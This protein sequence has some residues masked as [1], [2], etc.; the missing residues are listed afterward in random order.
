M[1]NLKILLLFPNTSSEGVLPLAVATLS[2][3]AKKLEAEVK[4]FETSFYRK[5]RSAGEEREYTGEYKPVKRESVF[6]LLPYERLLEDFLKTLEN[7]KPDIL[8]VSAN[9]LEYDLFCELI[10]GIQSI[11]PKPFV[12]VGGVEATIAPEDVIT[13]PY[14]DALCMGEGEKT[15]EEFL[16]KFKDGKD[17][18]NVRNLWVKTVSGVKKNLLRPLIDQAEL[19]ALPLDYSLFD[20][21]HFTKPFD[22]AMRRRGLLELSRGCPYSCN[23]CVNSAYK[24]I[25]KGMGKFF[26]IRPLD[27]LKE[28]T[29]KLMESGCEILQL[30]DESFLSIDCKILKEFCKWYSEEVKLPLL[31]QTRPESVTEKKVGL[32][33][34]MD[35]PIEISCGVESGSERILREI[36][37]RR[38]ELD[39]I[40][41]A[42]K[43][44]K[45]YGLYSKAYTMIGFPTETREDVF[46]T[47]FLIREIK[48]DKSIMSIFFPFK[49]T[50]LR[51]YCIEKGYISGDEKTRTFTD[52]SILKN[53]MMSTNEITG[54]RRT[55]RLYTKLPQKYFPQIELCE[56]S[57]EAHQ[58]LFTELVSLSW[59]LTENERSEIKHRKIFSTRQ[60]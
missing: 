42:F 4:Y 1:A 9:S 41:N 45:T 43:I 38:T 7:Y 13:N 24:N 53:Q 31:L 10:E 18:T 21:R 51:K 47:I 54:L 20:E 34:D 36:C 15:W 12:I 46:K 6:E 28:E 5:R 19:W 48:V 58:A 60:T 37:N 35:V 40:R 39:Q 3:I 56:K 59:Q 8:A 55:Y 26:R 57:Y 14:V 29:K 32:L 50:P 16:C 52:A 27:N 33:A 25:Y 11:K 2:A 49:G 30:Q 17:I 22:G 23:Y 44:I